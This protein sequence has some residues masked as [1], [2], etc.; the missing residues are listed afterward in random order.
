MINQ[1]DLLQ[2]K[3]EKE[4]NQYLQAYFRTIG[5]KYRF[6]WEVRTQQQVV[7]SSFFLPEVP[8]VDSVINIL[9]QSEMFTAVSIVHSRVEQG[10]LRICIKTASVTELVDK[11]RHAQYFNALLKVLPV[12]GILCIPSSE[13]EQLTIQKCAVKN[14]FQHVP[15]LLDLLMISWKV[16][17]SLKIV[18]PYHEVGSL[19]AKQKQ[20]CLDYLIQTIHPINTTIKVYGKGANTEY[21]SSGHDSVH[22]NFSD[23]CW[24]TTPAVIFEFERNQQTLS[25]LTALEP[26]LIEFKVSGYYDNDPMVPCG[27]RVKRI[28]DIPFIIKDIT[29]ASIRQNR[30]NYLDTLL[31]FKGKTKDY[32]F[33]GLPYEISKLILLQA[34]NDSVLLSE[35]EISEHIDK[36]TNYS[37]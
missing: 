24:S 3:I 7:S 19:I 37:L 34:C 28:I 32:G 11:F 6:T 2:I 30:S 31:T 29:F 35:D 23:N 12:S 26:E 10:K 20:L 16:L 1:A 33:S 4:L 14:G 25:D 21:L 27:I 15:K 17:P 18:I 8:D 36:I 5:L 22:L 13:R 9:K